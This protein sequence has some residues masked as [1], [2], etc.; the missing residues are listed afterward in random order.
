MHLICFESG[1]RI[2]SLC[3]IEILTL[4][5]M[6]ML[7]MDLVSYKMLYGNGILEVL[8]ILFCQLLSSSCLCNEVRQCLFF[9]PSFNVLSASV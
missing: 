9:Q 2:S 6:L 8:S 3:L 4:A 7:S 5:E 1:E